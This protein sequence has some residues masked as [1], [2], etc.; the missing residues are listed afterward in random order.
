MDWIVKLGG[1]KAVALWSALLVVLVLICLGR[2]VLP[3]DAAQARMIVEQSL[4]FLTWALGLFVGGNAIEHV[5]KVLPLMRG[6]A[7]PKADDK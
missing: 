4:G 5:A 6:A 2:W 1:R 7:V 3:A